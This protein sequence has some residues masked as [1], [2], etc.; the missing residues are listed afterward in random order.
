M[1]EYAHAMGNS[2]GNLQ[3]YWDI[4]EKYDNLQGGYIW[5]WVDQS[6][7]YKDEN[8]NPY[9]AY[10]HD[11]HPDLPTDGNFLNNGLV[12]PYRNPH[13]H[14]SEVKKVY[15]PIQIN[16][17][18]NSS[19]EI[20]NKN[21][22]TNLSDKTLSVKLLVDGKTHELK[23]NIELNV[24]PRN[25]SIIH[26]PEIPDMFIPE[27]EYIL[28]V[29]LIQKETNN[30][31]SKGHEVAWDQFT[32]QKSNA[33]N[34]TIPSNP[35]EVINEDIIQIKND[36]INLKIDSKTGEVISWHHK[37]REV[38]NNPI[39]PN[40]WRPPTDNDLG[41]GMDKW[42]KVWQETTYNYTS[43]LMSVPEKIQ[44]AVV[45]M[46]NYKSPN[47]NVLF[48][49][50][51]KIFP[52]GKVDIKFNYLS[53]KDNLPNIPRIGMY[54]TL[55]NTFTDVNWYG[56]GPSESYWDRKTGQK[57]GLYSGKTD[58][59]FHRYSRPQET[60]N[61]TDVRWI[62]VSNKELTLKAF[63][64]E[65]LN[66]SVWPFA[67]TELDFSSEDAGA[68]ASGLV[69]VTKKH[70]ADIKIRNTIQWN[71]DYLQ[72]GVGGDTSWGR[73]VHPEYTIPANKAYQ[74]TFTIQPTL[75]N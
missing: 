57:T 56:K 72:M 47:N 50:L 43:N 35:L 27:S 29:S 19:I 63:S 26:I 23:S 46:I 22:F 54:M 36:I 5:D 8:G 62:E 11:Y 3:D 60:G 14:L 2:V 69:P 4:I 64:N 59:Q 31:I 34:I 48:D 65:Y 42:A 52:S 24:A 45:F 32:L 53:E 55:S 25:K 15:E 30:L 73:L 51:Y 39:K 38:T 61:K 37:G 33:F 74:Y 1:I 58:N 18:G 28:E 13:P 21:F 9:L 10:G 7:E 6:L 67:M 66:S 49:A 75:K 44:D 68:S 41:N 16:Y 12:D 70:G 17:L 71:I 40:F 20:E